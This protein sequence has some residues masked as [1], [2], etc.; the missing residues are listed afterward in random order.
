MN[1]GLYHVAILERWIFYYCLNF[2]FGKDLVDRADSDHNCSPDWRNAGPPW[3]A[4]R[5][6]NECLE[7]K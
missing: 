5:S 6:K 4:L 7:R 2:F 3:E 1:C